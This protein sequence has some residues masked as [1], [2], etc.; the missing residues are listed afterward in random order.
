MA[1]FSPQAARPLLGSDDPVE[2]IVLPLV[3][4]VK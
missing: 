4:E 1:I 2:M 3:G